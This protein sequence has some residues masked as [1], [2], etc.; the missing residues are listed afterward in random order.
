MKLTSSI[1]TATIATTIAASALLAP[2]AT[3]L[4][5]DTSGL[6]CV[7]KWTAAEQQLIKDF[8]LDR[9][10]ADLLARHP[11]RADDLTAF[12]AYARTTS[13][14]LAQVTGA[15]TTTAA[16]DVDLEASLH[17]Y[18]ANTKVVPAATDVYVTRGQARSVLVALQAGV[19]S[20]PE[21]INIEDALERCANSTVS[22]QPTGSSFGSS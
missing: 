11:E 19:V 2:T 21:E 9:A 22:I 5:V 3:A 7:L 10:E 17:T 14:P 4:Q 15:A 13:E 6:T 20:F 12:F 18:A 1:L 8:D 16:G